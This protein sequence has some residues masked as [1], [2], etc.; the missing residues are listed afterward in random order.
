MVIDG[1]NRMITATIPHPRRADAAETY[2]AYFLRYL[3]STFPA[4]RD[5]DIEL[6]AYWTGV[7]NSSS[8]VYHNDF[9]KLY[10]VA[11]GVMALINLGTWGN[12]MGPLL[13]MNLAEA[14]AAERPQDLLMPVDTASAVR[15]PRWFEFKIRHLLIPAARLADRFGLA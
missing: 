12:L 10:Q 1:R 3:H 2:F 7:T 4:T 14:V 13:G 11:D 5:A 6:E 15:F 8:H 9:A